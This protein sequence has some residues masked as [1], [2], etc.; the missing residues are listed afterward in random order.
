[1]LLLCF[2]PVTGPE[3]FA[4]RGIAHDEE[5][6]GLGSQGIEPRAVSLGKPPRTYGIGRP[7]VHPSDLEDITAPDKPSIHLQLDVRP[8][9]VVVVRDYE[10]PPIE[11]HGD[12]Q[13]VVGRFLLRFIRGA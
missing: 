11:V 7:C 1:M 12:L 2:L 3:A 9:E 8:V 10:L 13:G 5:F 6:L 4:L